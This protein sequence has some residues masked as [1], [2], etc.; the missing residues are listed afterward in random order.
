MRVLRLCSALIVI[1]ALGSLAESVSASMAVRHMN[2]QQM[3]GAAGR[4]FRGTVLG[5]KDGA[6]TVGGGS[7]H[8]RLPPPGRRGIQGL[9]RNVKGE[10]DRDDPDDPAVEDAAGR[11]GAPAPGRSR[12]PKFEQ[13]H[14][15]LIL[16]TTPSVAGLSTTVGLGQGAFKVGGKVGQEI[17]VNGNNNIGLYAGM[18]VAPVKGAR[19]V[20]HAAI[21]DPQHRRT[22]KRGAEHALHH[23][24]VR[25][26]RARGIDDDGDDC[27]PAAD[28]ARQRTSGGL[29][30][31]QPFLWPAGGTNIPYNP[32][33]GDLGPLPNARGRA[34]RH[35]V[36]AWGAI[37][38]ATTTYLNAGPLPVDVDIT[39]FVPYLEPTAPDGLSAIVFDDTGEIF[40][41]LF[42]PGSGVLGF[43]G[44]EWV[45]TITC[46]ILEGCLSSTG[47]HSATR[48]R[49]WTCWSTSS[50]T[51]RTSRIRPST[52]RSVIGDHSGPSPNNTFGVAGARADRDDVPVLLRR[53]SGTATPHKDDIAVLST[54]YPEPDF[55]CDDG[56]DQRHDLR[57]ERHDEAHRGE[58]HRAQ[59]AESVQRRRVGAL[60]RLRAG[61]QPG[62]GRWPAGTRCAASHPAPSTP[63]SWTRS[64][65]GLQHSAAHAAPWP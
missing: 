20:L 37:P 60:E 11:S 34:R 53:R 23:S 58:R 17:A 30:A 32:D 3:C 45:N 21:P 27:G 59:R 14:D 4:I 39:N 57:D 12:S 9:V 38:S 6:V 29:H 56:S 50:A 64:W 47:R 41:L 61:L 16:A 48:P 28:R 2:L 43:A 65:R 7:C 36:R 26:P 10:G 1:G 62:V 15:Y 46:D 42:G 35:G 55:L 40:N 8:R 18:N 19:G 25:P 44:P 49:R 52:A 63:S 33:Q 54:L 31:G 24:L 22:L 13:G 51:T 5:V